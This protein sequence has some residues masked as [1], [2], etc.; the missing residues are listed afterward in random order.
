MIS[1]LNLTCQYHHN[2]GGANSFTSNG[3]ALWEGL[4]PKKPGVEDTH[5]GSRE[6][7]KATS[8]LQLSGT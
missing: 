7:P 2:L 5:P 6:N 3:G 4:D 8:R 1:N